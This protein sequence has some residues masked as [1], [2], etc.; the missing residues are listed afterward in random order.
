[1]SV[2]SLRKV[3]IEVGVSLCMLVKDSFSENVLFGD[4]S[5]VSGKGWRHVEKE[6]SKKQ[7]EHYSA[8]GL[9]Y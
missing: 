1:M 9:T 7:E 6:A 8:L 2:I 4:A 3:I 5:N